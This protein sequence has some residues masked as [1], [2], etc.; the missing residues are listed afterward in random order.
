MQMASPASVILR[1]IFE[2]GFMPSVQS[3][4]LIILHSAK[5]EI[6]THLKKVCTL[7]TI[8]PCHDTP[9]SLFISRHT[10]KPS[11]QLS[12]DKPTNSQG[13]NTINGGG[14]NPVFNDN[15]RLNVC[16]VDSSLKWFVQLSIAYTGVMP[17]VTAISAMPG[18]RMQSKS[19]FL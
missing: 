8:P 7:A 5:E 2:K 19:V 14:R 1:L 6:G 11:L 10:K 13:D 9:P 16:N 15:L 3:L 12:I 4:S 18:F 17:D